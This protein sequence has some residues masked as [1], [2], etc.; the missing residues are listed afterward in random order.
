MKDRVNTVKGRELFRPLAPA[1]LKEEGA[2]WFEGTESLLLRAMVGVVT[3]RPVARERTPAALHVDGTA[4]LQI[5]DRAWNERFW[6]VIKAFQAQTGVPLVL[7]TSFNATGEPIVE[8]PG[9]AVAASRKMRLDALVLGN[10]VVVAHAHS[11][12]IRLAL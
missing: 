2:A 11:Q 8:T 6:A 9:D 1:V 12:R 4:R 3:A 7:N 10:Y 5:V